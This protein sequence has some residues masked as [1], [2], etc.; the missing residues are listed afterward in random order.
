VKAHR[1]VPRMSTMVVHTYCRPPLV[2]TWCT[3][4]GKV[5]FA[6]I[7]AFRLPRRPTLTAPLPQSR[8]PEC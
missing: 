8:M 6:R 1:H 5:M 7:G 3:R 2:G 4:Y